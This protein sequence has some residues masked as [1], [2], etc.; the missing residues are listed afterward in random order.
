M[1]IKKY[2][3]NKNWWCQMRD[4]GRAKLIILNGIITRAGVTNCQSIP[5]IVNPDK[6]DIINAFNKKWIIREISTCLY[7]WNGL[8]QGLMILTLQHVW[9]NHNK[10]KQKGKMWIWLSTKVTNCKGLQG[11]ALIWFTPRSSS[12]ISRRPMSKSESQRKMI[13][14]RKNKS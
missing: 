7:V 5:T 9:L 11:E 8:R 2:I 6:A 13:A 4:T 12:E 14:I 3:D 10:K 1:Q